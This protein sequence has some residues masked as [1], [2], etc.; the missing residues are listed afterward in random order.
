VRTVDGILDAVDRALTA[1]GPARDTI[2]DICLDVQQR[3][4]TVYEAADR[5]EAATGPGSGACCKKGARL[6][7]DWVA[8]Y[9]CPEHGWQ[10]G[11]GHAP[12]AD[13]RAAPE[14]P[15]RCPDCDRERCTCGGSRGTR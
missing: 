13:H 5:I 8:R 10:D 6:A 3:R 14:L 9:K 15:P 12:R 2:I 4:A 1:T 11:P 7:E